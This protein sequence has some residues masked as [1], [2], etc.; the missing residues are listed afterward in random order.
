MTTTLTY[1]DAA[2]TPDGDL[3]LPVRLIG[4]VDLIAQRIRIRLRTHLGEWPLDSE[5][6]LDYAGWAGRVPVPL[7]EIELALT[8]VIGETPGVA[9][10]SGA[11]ASFDPASREVRYRADL[12]L[13]D[14]DDGLGPLTPLSLR[15]AVTGA[16]A[17]RILIAPF[18][19]GGIVP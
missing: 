2:L 13:G 4:G 7:V 19:S 15:I 5:V 12:L 9:R 18:I 10:I 8:R 11:Q 6:G 1:R 14:A 16:G 3:E 17:S